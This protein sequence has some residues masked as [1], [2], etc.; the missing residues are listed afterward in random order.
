MEEKE[1]ILLD[2]INKIKQLINE[3]NELISK[4]NDWCRK[5]SSFAHTDFY[6]KS[7]E[8]QIILNLENKLSEYRNRLMEIRGE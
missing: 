4:C 6:P 5:S 2:R 8:K 3:G 1:Q 7:R